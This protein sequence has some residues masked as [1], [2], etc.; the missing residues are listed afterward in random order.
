[1]YVIHP[2]W[3]LSTSTLCVMP[4]GI[5]GLA[6]NQAHTLW[7]PFWMAA[8][9]KLGGKPAQEDGRPLTRT[10]EFQRHLFSSHLLHG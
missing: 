1:M 8:Q 2:L 10:E 5:D 7:T 6:R 3:F 9:V 4:L